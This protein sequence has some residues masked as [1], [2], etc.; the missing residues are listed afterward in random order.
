MK[1]ILILST[2]LLISLSGYG[3]ILKG[4]GSSSNDAAQDSKIAS[5]S[6]TTPSAYLGQSSTGCVIPNN[7]AG[8]GLTWL[9]ANWVGVARDNLVNPTLVFANWR[10]NSSNQEVTTGPG[11]I[12]VA[13]NYPVGSATYYVA[14]ECIAASGGPVAF[15]VGNTALTFNVTIPKGAKYAV[16]S[17]QNTPLGAVWHQYQGP[18]IA[19][20]LMGFINGNNGTP[21]DLTTS[22]TIASS[23]NLTYGPVL[24][25]S[26]TTQPSLAIVGDSREAGG[27][28]FAKDANYDIGLTAKI[29][30]SQYGYT[31]FAA[32]GTL[33]AQWN[34]TSTTYRDQ[35]LSGNVPGLPANTPYFT[36]MALEYGVNDFGTGGDTPTTLAGRVA[37]F[38]AKYSAYMPIVLYTLAPYNQSSDFWTTLSGQAPG[39]NQPKINL[40]NNL[41]RAGIANVYAVWDVSDTVDPFRQGTWQVSRNPSAIA[42]TNPVSFTGAISG[43]TLTVSAVSSGS[44]KIG[45]SFTGSG[46]Q[47]ST[48]ITGFGTATGATGTY[49]VNKIHSASYPY[50][51]IVASTAMTTGAA[52]SQDGLHYTV[53][54]EENAERVA[55]ARLIQLMQR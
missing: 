21:T 33:I 44:L 49:T 17:L 54:A 25:L 27:P 41:V 51:G 55:G 8:T 1:Q 37:T 13:I 53:V 35:L 48:I 31:N 20:P 9:M 19:D 52:F 3:Q 6:A 43:T 29:V 47:A 45:D 40:Y 4:G 26:K 23:T 14:N 11:T 18:Y 24:V 15:P 16:R 7:S 50:P 39:S 30:G 28:G 22:G 42:Y 36:R 38:T 12:K 34:S 2:L 5:I 46:V 32:A 10:I